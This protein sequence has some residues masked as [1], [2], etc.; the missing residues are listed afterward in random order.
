MKKLLALI[1]AAVCIFAAA[2]V[3]VY[4][5]TANGSWGEVPLYKGAITLDGK[6][7]DIYK[8]G[9]I[10]KTADNAGC[11]ATL[12]LIH[13]G[14]CLWLLADCKSAYALGDYNKANESSNA[15]K[16]TAN[17]VMLDWNNAAG[18][19]N[20]FH[21]YIAWFTGEYWGFR[22]AKPEDIEVKATVDKGAQTFIIEYK[23][24]FKGPAKTGSEVGFNFMLDCDKN[25]GA[26]ATSERVISYLLDGIANEYDKYKN[27]TLSTKEIALKVETTA[28]AKPAAD[29]NK[30][31]AAQTFD[32]AAV[33]M[34]AALLSGAAL[35]IKKRK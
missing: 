10:L 21:K 5:L 29:A 2:S 9:L 12:Y 23:C 11:S 30:P 1:L 8:E 15:W 4:A 25:M 17:E 18:D 31:A 16:T 28:A 13:D 3:P 14:A 22:Q 20:A 35:V 6:L 26:N 32:P 24:P 19:A 7:D 27:I 34:A 33:F